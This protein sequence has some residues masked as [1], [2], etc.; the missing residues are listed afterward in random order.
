MQRPTPTEQPL[1]IRKPGARGGEPIIRDTALTVRTIV[2]RVL[3]ESGS[4][5]TRQRIWNQ[6]NGLGGAKIRSFPNSL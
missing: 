2:Q 5:G 3:S 4:R 6:T 1:I